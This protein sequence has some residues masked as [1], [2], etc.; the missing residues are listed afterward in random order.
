MSSFSRRRALGGGAAFLSLVLSVVLITGL[1]LANV[2]VSS[3][4]TDGDHDKVSVQKQANA[5]T[6]NAGDTVT[7]TISVT[8]Q[9]FPIDGVVLTDTLPTG[10]TGNWT[11]S[12][13]DAVAAGC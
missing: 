5:A 4:Q 11:V 9:P 13:A 10:I 6:L 1:L 3:A 8:T 12:G 2:G 7:F